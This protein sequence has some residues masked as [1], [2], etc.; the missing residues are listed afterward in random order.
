MKRFNI[1]SNVYTRSIVVFIVLY[2]A[3][4][5]TPSAAKLTRSHVAGRIMRARVH[6]VSVDYIGILHLSLEAVQ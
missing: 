4:N 5:R 2:T 6:S 1:H 3:L